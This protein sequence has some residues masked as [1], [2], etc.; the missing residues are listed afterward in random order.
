[1][2]AFPA[3]AAFIA[4]I[5]GYPIPVVCQPLSQG[6]AITYQVSGQFGVAT[7]NTQQFAGTE[8][9]VTQFLGILYGYTI[10]VTV[11]GQ[12]VTLPPVPP[13]T[14]ITDEN[15][16]HG[17]GYVGIPMFIALA[18]CD[19]WTSTEPTQ[20]GQ[21]LLTAIHEAMHAK[22]ADGNEALTECRAMQALPTE[23]AALWPNVSDPGAEPPEP[24]QP[25]ETARWKKSH[26]AAWRR[27]LAA[28]RARYARWQPVGAQWLN[29]SSDWSNYQAILQ[30]AAQMDS[31]EPAQYH[32]AIC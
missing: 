24:L 32:G 7:V 26:P 9:G 17:A 28:Y 25:T 8:A 2:P 27:L 12:A 10:T 6:S 14:P 20:R 23:L 4:G 19:G 15:P 11:A 31:S 1:M 16:S 5:V 30:A 22:Y 18:N 3:L 21:T 29:A 13:D